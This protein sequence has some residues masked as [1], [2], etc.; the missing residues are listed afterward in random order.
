MMNSAT[1]RAVDPFKPRREPAL[2]LYQAFQAEAAKRGD[3]EFQ[4]WNQAEIQAVHSAAVEAYPAHG[5]PVPTLEEVAD[6]ERYAQGSCDYGATWIYM[7]ER[8]MR[9]EPAKSR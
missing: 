5:L 8:M 1:R 4:D 9:R 3:R 2:T 6:A 7:V